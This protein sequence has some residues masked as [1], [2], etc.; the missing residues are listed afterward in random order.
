MSL[1]LQVD[2]LGEYKNLTAAT[3]GA[4]NQLSAL[5]KRTAAISNS[6]NRAFAAIGIGFSLGMVVR[7]LGE[8]SRAAVEDV[9]SQA[10]LA[11]QMRNTTNATDQQVAAVEK[12]ISKLQ[13][14]ASIADDKLRPSFSTLLRVTK[15]S[16]KAMDLLTLAT[17]VSAGSGKDLTAVTMA[18]SKAYQGKMGALQKLGVPMTDSIQ[19]AQDYAKATATL[20]KLTDL[21]ANQSGPALLKT[22]QKIAIQREILN[23]LAKDGIDWEKD[24]GDAFANSATKAANL[25][26]YQRMQII[27]GEMQEQIGTALLPILG[28]LST[29]LATPEGEEKLG[30]LVDLIKEV[31]TN[32]AEMAKWVLDNKDWLL[33]MVAAIG[34]VTSAWKIATGAVEAY[35]A[36]TLIAGIIGAG[37]ALLGAGAVGAGVGGYMT[38]QAKSTERKIY[39]DVFMPQLNKSKTKTGV[40]QYITIKG[41]Q[42]AQEINKIIGKSTKS[43]GTQPWWMK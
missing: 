1:V 35:K 8:A 42:S 41:S 28:E 43:T 20:N 6:M 37:G 16:S 38:E 10:L 18:L 33:P 19:N 5:N 29:W 40:T 26:P 3:K 7:E 31:V 4:Q 2:I 14:S 39:G 30:Q 21:A 34:A 17:D 15:D 32:F 22:Q 36:A 23:Q 11:N 12:Q 24:L 25:D 13:L 9:K 27:F